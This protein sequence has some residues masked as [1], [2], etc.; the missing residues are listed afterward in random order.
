VVN[1]RGW[2]D[3]ACG[4]RANSAVTAGQLYGARVRLPS[5]SSAAKHLLIAPATTV[6]VQAQ[7]RRRWFL[8]AGDTLT[9][10]VYSQEANRGAASGIDNSFGECLEV[11]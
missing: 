9:F 3:V 8:T 4:A 1:Y 11:L 7:G 6:E 2:Y 5:G 10:Q